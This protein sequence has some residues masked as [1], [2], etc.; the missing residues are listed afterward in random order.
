MCIRDRE[1]TELWE[2]ILAEAKKAE[3]EEA[4]GKPKDD[5]GDE[6][7]EEATAGVSSDRKAADR[8]NFTKRAN[9]NGTKKKSNAKPLGEPHKVIIRLPSGE[10]KQEQMHRSETFSDLMGRLG[11]GAGEYLV[12]EG[13]MSI[14]EPSRGMEDYAEVFPSGE[15]ATLEVL[16]LAGARN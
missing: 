1:W 11:L 7:A 3:E 12:G 6:E 16:S 14:L 10:A 2:E 9:K 13:S 5:H 4:E 8:A 15:V